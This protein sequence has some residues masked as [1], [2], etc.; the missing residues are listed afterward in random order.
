MRQMWISFVPN[1]KNA[2]EQYFKEI[3]KELL[4]NLESNLWRVRQSCCDAFADIFSFK[5]IKDLQP[6]LITIIS[7]IFRGKIKNQY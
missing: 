6:Y 3:M 5:T 2:I 1:S 4:D 7:G